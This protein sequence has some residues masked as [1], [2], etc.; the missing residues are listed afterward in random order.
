MKAIFVSLMV[1]AALIFAPVPMQGQSDADIPKLIKALD[2]SRHAVV[3]GAINKLG[4]QGSAAKDAVP[5]LAKFLRKNHKEFPV[6][7]AKA[8]AKIGAP[9]VPELIKVLDDPSETIRIRVLLALGTIGREA[10][11][12]AIPVGKLLE[13]ENAKLRLL[14]ALVL[15]AMHEEARPTAASLAKALRDTDGKIRFVAADSLYQIGQPAIPYLITAAKDESREVRILALR[16][17]GRF[18]ESDDALQTLAVGLKD[19]DRQ[20]RAVAAA[21]ISRLGSLAKSVLPQLLENLEEQNQDVQVNVFAAIMGLSMH[22][23]KDL[24]D[25]LT[26]VNENNRWA[27]NRPL[28]LDGKKT[29]LALLNSP[30]PTHRLAATLA[31]AKTGATAQEAF[32]ILEKMEKD[33]SLSVRGAAI[34]ARAAI[35]PVAKVNFKK[36][37]DCI[38]DSVD[39]AKVDPA[40]LIRL[41]ILLSA[42]P[43]FLS[44]RQS[45]SDE[46][47]KSFE[48]NQILIRRLLD[49]F[50]FKFDDIPDLIEGINVVAQFNLGFT[51]PFSRL[52]FKLQNL[53]QDS[54]DPRTAVL[55]FTNLGDGV[56]PDSPCWPAIQRQWAEMLRKVPVEYLILEKK[57]NV[58]QKE[59]IIQQHALA[60]PLIQERKRSLKPK[61]SSMFEIMEKSRLQQARATWATRLS[62]S[63]LSSAA[64]IS[65]LHTLG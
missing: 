64:I 15:G 6:E 62:Q 26:A 35:A 50:Q 36:L 46:L 54:E 14:A 4:N 60:F 34:L 3:L 9:A 5:A 59:E 63:G 11:L 25:A 38:S 32:P 19:R 53:V 61:Q 21:S 27:E 31:L 8:L 56:L 17:L 22:R 7:A 28:G 30:N 20:V 65:Q 18:L 44:P 42:M 57:M 47:K 48:K 52:S 51:E 13:N 41:H 12:A 49:D 10:R 23:D 24:R 33:S 55:A 37:D 45:P 40:E 2:D 16:T 43:S 29:L 1:I 39:N 58:K